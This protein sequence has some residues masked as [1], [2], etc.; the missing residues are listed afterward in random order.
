MTPS[1]FHSNENVRDQNKIFYNSLNFGQKSV[2]SS[3]NKPFVAQENRKKILRKKIYKNYE[4]L[5][6]NWRKVEKIF[7]KFYIKFGESL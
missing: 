1:H 3:E 4:I 5:K 7:T 2:N 6:K